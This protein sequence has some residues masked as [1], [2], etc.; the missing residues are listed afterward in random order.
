MRRRAAGLYE[1]LLSKK[2]S[3]SPKLTKDS[4]NSMIFTMFR[5]MEI[6]FMPFAGLLG[7]RPKIVAERLLQISHVQ[8]K[9]FIITVAPS[10]RSMLG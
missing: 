9:T 4:K 2:A 1:G 7:F 6:T 5:P 3:I 8:S 10:Q